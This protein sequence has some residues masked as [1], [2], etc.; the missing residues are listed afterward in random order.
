MD[1]HSDVDLTELARRALDDDLV[2][3]QLMRAV[4]A[5]AQR[6]C[7]ARLAGYGASRQLAEDVAQEI[8]IAVLEALPRYRHQGVPFEAFVY[9]IGSRKVADAQRT[10]HRMPVVLFDEVPET[11]SVPSPEHDVLERLE[12][13]DVMSL[14]DSLPT[15]LREVLV[16]R[17]ALGLPATQVGL[18]LGMS[19]G[20]VRIAQHR[21]LQRLRELHLNRRATRG[22]VTA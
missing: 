20:A 4:R 10:H 11:D 13:E 5:A 9:A 12:V 15:R 17:V 18:T 16:M 7:R 1:A 8:C 3:D 2:M 6:Y 19:A 14:L 21:A 22:E